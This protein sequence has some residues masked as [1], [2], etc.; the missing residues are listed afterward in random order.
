MWKKWLFLLVLSF[1][2]L[3]A[4]AAVVSIYAT[5]D[6]YIY[7]WTGS[8]WQGISN[9]SWKNAYHLSLTQDIG[10][11]YTLYFAVKSPAA[12]AGF[13]ADMTLSEGAFSST[14][15]NQLLSDASHWQIA[16]INY[17]TDTLTLNPTSISSWETPESYAA[18]SDASSYWYQEN[19]DAPISNISDDA[20]WI[21]LGNYS[22]KTAAVVK[23]EYSIERRGIYGPVSTVPEP[24]PLLLLTIG[25]LFGKIIGSKKVN[26]E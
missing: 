1:L 24:A 15:T 13:L 9:R 22:G 14:S 11:S 7:Y 19:G 26:K 18:N 12:K 8:D 25:I 6:N 3:S 20:E 5:G 17:W 23:V 10:S 4:R 2:S 16:S 21:W